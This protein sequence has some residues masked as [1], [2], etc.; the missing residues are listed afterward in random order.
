MILTACDADAQSTPQSPTPVSPPSPATRST[1]PPTPERPATA[2]PP[3]VGAPSRAAPH[4][5]SVDQL[6]DELERVQAQK[7]ELEDRERELKAAVRAALGRQAERVSKLGAAAEAEPDRV[8]QVLLEGFAA[9]DEERVRRALGLVPGQVLRYPA[10][11]EASVR[12]EKAG[13]AGVTVEVVPNGL[14]S[15]YKDI[16]VRSTAELDR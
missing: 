6:L 15:L 3:V 11:Q 9:K 8:G 4:K 16:R 10:L 14:D 13:F 5:K 2:T 12:L 7:A 1:W